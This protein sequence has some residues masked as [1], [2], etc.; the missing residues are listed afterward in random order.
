[1]IVFEIDGRSIA[2]ATSVFDADHTPSN[3]RSI[4]R[5]R[6]L[7]SELRRFKL[8]IGKEF[9]RSIGRIGTTRVARIGHV[10][11]E[12]PRAYVRLIY[13]AH[14]RK[15]ERYL[16]TG[17]CEVHER[18]LL[19]TDMDVLAASLTAGMSKPHRFS[20]FPKTE[21]ALGWSSDQESKLRTMQGT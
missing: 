13:V 15:N 2:L 14:G 5:D 4:T 21:P 9:I 19:V 12:G 6:I 3:S 20:L 17:I 10:V 8:R 1:M 7:R 11:A 16:F 18:N